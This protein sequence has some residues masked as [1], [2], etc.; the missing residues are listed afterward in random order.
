MS[1]SFQNKNQLTLTECF[2]KNNIY[3]PS[4]K[5]YKDRGSAIERVIIGTGYPIALLDKPSFRAMLSTYDS[6]CQVFG[7]FTYF[8]FDL[9]F[10]NLL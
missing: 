1:S 6:K 2:K 10:C 8:M 9:H 4:S 5:E 3:L 7:E